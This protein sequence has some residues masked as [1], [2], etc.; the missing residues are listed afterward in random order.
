MQLRL[1][2][3]AATALTLV[4]SPVA[5]AGASPDGS[6]RPMLYRHLKQTAAERAAQARAKSF[7]AKA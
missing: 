2:A 4:I 3:V 7:A 1:I 5:A 6:G